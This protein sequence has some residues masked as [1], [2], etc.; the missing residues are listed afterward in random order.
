MQKH[1][2]CSVEELRDS[3]LLF[4][5][6]GVL[7]QESRDFVIIFKVGRFF[8]SIPSVTSEVL[9]MRVGTNI[10]TTATF[11]GKIRAVMPYRQSWNLLDA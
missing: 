11:L 10:H 5:G 4:G 6:S 8:W 9:E 2:I 7:T 1:S 3:G